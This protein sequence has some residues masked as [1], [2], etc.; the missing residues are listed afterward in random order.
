[1]ASAPLLLL[2]DHSL[3]TFSNQRNYF[4]N[5]DDKKTVY[6][7]PKEI[8]QDL[9]VF[10]H[11]SKAKFPVY[12]VG[13]KVNKQYYA[14]K[15]FEYQNNQPHPYFKNEV[16]FA[17]FQHPYVIRN[18]YIENNKEIDS[19]KT[20]TRRASY[21]IMEYAPYGDFFDLIKDHGSEIDSKLA[22]TYFRQ[23]IDGLEY[24][25]KNGVAHMD[26]KLE[27][28]LVGKDYALK[29]ADFDFSHFENDS[30]VI[31]RGT[32]FYRAPEILNGKCKN[33]K[34]ADIYSAGIVLFTFI[35]KGI[36]PHSEN[37]I[38]KGT[39]LSELLHYDT[40]KFWIIHSEIMENKT[41][42]FDKD[43]KELFIAMTR[44]QPE[45]RISIEDIKK[46]QWYNRPSYSFEEVKAIVGKILNN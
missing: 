44:P 30:E 37:N 43:F 39:N 6:G 33:T 21:I 26:L 31:S 41:S 12:L 19:P 35:T 8:Y 20:D 38:I 17:C 23:L 14:M 18:L 46:S 10:K 15:V 16:R 34:A 4:N 24:L 3:P 13:S 2:A 7:N 22:R 28:L 29:I 45:D 27:N 5:F 42:I 32:K 36:L 40:S 11:L 9:F 25:H 1:M